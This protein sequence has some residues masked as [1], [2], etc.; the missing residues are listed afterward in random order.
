MVHG[1]TH[2]K[3]FFTYFLNNLI[4]VTTYYFVLRTFTPA[5]DAN[6]NDLWS[7]YSSEI[8]VTLPERLIVFLPITKK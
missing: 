4:P 6:Q 8:S 1:T 5:H 3:L 2:D 7:E